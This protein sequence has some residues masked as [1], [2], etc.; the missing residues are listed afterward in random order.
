MCSLNT[1]QKRDYINGEGYC[2]LHNSKGRYSDYCK[3]NDSNLFRSNNINL[4][5]HPS[6]SNLSEIKK[7][8]IRNYVIDLLGNNPKNCFKDIIYDDRF[9]SLQTISDRLGISRPTLK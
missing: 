9:G 7:Q 1:C 5:S 3:E 2:G 4:G 6:G 8:K